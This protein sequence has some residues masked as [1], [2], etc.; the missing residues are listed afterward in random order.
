MS[1]LELAQRIS[2]KNTFVHV[3]ADE[4]PDAEWNTVERERCRSDMTHVMTLS[5]IQERAKLMA[6]LQEDMA[7]VSTEGTATPKDATPTSYGAFSPNEFDDEQLRVTLAKPPG[8]RSFPE[9][10]RFAEPIFHA[11]EDQYQSYR[12]PSAE[13][14]QPYV[15]SAADRTMHGY[16]L[17]ENQQVPVSLV[18]RNG[19]TF[20]ILPM[21]QMCRD[22]PRESPKRQPRSVDASPSE[23]H[24]DC[25]LMLRNIPNKYTQSALLDD[26]DAYRASFNF[27]YLPTDFKNHCNL[28]YAFINF[29]NKAAA[30]DFVQEYDGKRLPRFPQSPKVLAV[31][32]ARIQGKDANIE[33]LRSSSVMGV[34]DSSTKPLVFEGGVSVDFP[35]P[36]CE[37]PPPGVR[38]KRG[39][40]RYKEQRA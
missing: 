7:E 8:L 19:Q 17:Q 23:L 10:D 29:T 37:L 34:L 13:P 14:A 21:Q 25:T 9:S 28:G 3:E 38:R 4:D 16:M 24:D 6:L 20:A 32:K 35:E 5:A 31:Q 39:T 2:V 12:M 22:E 1:A 15:M 18:Q 27:F 40:A 36:L 30:V 33:R 11:P 26:L